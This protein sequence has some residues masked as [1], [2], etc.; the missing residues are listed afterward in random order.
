VP[1]SRHVKRNKRSAVFF[2][3]P[4]NTTPGG[5]N[6]NPMV[7]FVADVNQRATFRYDTLGRFGIE[8]IRF[9]KQPY[10]T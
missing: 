9:G 5:R 6:F 2:N 7:S 10:L 4:T 8:R 1:R 3:N